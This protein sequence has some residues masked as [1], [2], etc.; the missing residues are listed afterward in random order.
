[1]HTFESSACAGA[2]EPRADLNWRLQG[3]IAL[4]LSLRV[5][6]VVKQHHHRR[7]L[8]FARLGGN[9]ARKSTYA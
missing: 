8:S 2:E 6:G 7:R 4:I 1:M 9:R 5:E 3:A